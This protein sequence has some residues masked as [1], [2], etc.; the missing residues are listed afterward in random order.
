MA[1]PL[2]HP[3]P[4]VVT[5]TAQTCWACAFESWS[6]ANAALFGTSSGMTAR[7]LIDLFRRDPGL[8]YGHTARASVDGIRVLSALGLMELRGYRTSQLRLEMIGAALESGYI[9]LIYFRVG[10]PAHAVVLYGADTTNLHVMDPM[11]QAGLV[12][13]PANHLLTLPRGRAVFGLPLVGDL[14]RATSGAAR[15]SLASALAGAH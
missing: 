7:E 11:P 3:E 9:Y 6:R 10:R 4:P 15:P 8:T 14:L 1:I 13:L 12:D 5:Q 2:V